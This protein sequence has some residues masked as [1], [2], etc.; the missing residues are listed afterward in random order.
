MEISLLAN[1][2]GHEREKLIRQLREAVK[3]SSGAEE[4]L[5]G[6][7][8]R[9]MRETSDAEEP[10]AAEAA[11]KVMGIK[12]HGSTETTVYEIASRLR[13]EIRRASKVL[14]PDPGADLTHKNYAIQVSQN[15]PSFQRENTEPSIGLLL[16]DASDIFVGDLIQ[17]ITEVCDTHAYDLMID[18]SSDDPISET[19]KLQRLLRRTHGVLIVPTSDRT[20]S[21]M[22]SQ[23]L[24][25]RDCVLVDRYFRDLPD[26]P[27][28]HSDDISA[29]RQAGTYLKQSGCG[30]VL[31]VDQASRSPNSFAITPLEDR[32]RGCQ[33]QLADLAV[34][35][36]LRAA[37]S[38][39][40][41]GFDAL[42]QFE[43]KQ[44]LAPGDGIYAL[45][46]R[47]AVGCRHYLATRKPPLDL[48]VIGTEGQAF[49]DFMQPP[50]LSIKF[51]SVEMGRLAAAVLFAKL[52]EA[53]LP[54]SE[55]QPHYLI[56][57]F[58]LIPSKTSLGRDR[59]PIS[60]SDAASH[61]STA[62]TG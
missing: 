42:E 49:G 41:G 51:D 12:W 44:P 16:A 1:W 35:R 22:I 31:I 6:E 40:Q 2:R 58:L 32:V 45:T 62:K 52:Q 50:L 55:C 14:R 24:R 43:K 37:G 36:H 47:L 25:D 29:G 15:P 28:V 10:L 18:V 26:V 48:P 21:P 8:L 46:D 53:D 13:K 23:I 56:P 39:E 34:V 59:I 7:L 33:I 5:W 54:R 4:K 20:L 17:G 19:K 30:R 27:C 9:R 61:Y 60:F 38:D 11:A 3:V 57:P